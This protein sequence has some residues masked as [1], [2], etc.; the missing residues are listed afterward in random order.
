MADSIITSTLT[1]G[2]DPVPTS[3]RPR[4][5]QR[6]WVINIITAL[7]VVATLLG[8]GVLALP[9][10]I[11]TTGF[12]PFLIGFSV[13]VPFKM[14]SYMVMAELLLHADRILLR[15]YPLSYFHPSLEGSH[16]AGEPSSGPENKISKLGDPD[17]SAPVDSV[18]RESDAARAHSSAS[19]HSQ[20]AT[21]PFTMSGT[22][23]ETP[24]ISGPP[25]D[26][27]AD[28]PLNP[29]LSPEDSSGKTDGIWSSP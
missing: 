14:L 22:L 13:V 5:I 3:A 19:S 18:G 10:R 6:Q 2:P 28:P 17:D 29:T 9:V 15:N 16:G 24:M 23:P 11:A 25:S 4:F 21:Q 27:D 26:F 12:W 7:V 8:T 20:G 1:D